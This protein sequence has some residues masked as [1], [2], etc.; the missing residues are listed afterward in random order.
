MGGTRRSR[1]PFPRTAKPVAGRGETSGGA[2]GRRRR[3]DQ[4]LR[5]RIRA[6]VERDAQA[7]A[8]TAAKAL[9]PAHGAGVDAQR[10]PEVAVPEL[11]WLQLLAGGALGRGC[12][13]CPD[14]G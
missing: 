8:A 10:V 11:G 12:A 9:G 7:R 6:V 13:R 5:E 1:P 14:R 2:A 3:A 4:Q